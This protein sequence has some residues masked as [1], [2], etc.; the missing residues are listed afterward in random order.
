MGWCSPAGAASTCATRALP[1]ILARSIRYRRL[2]WRATIPA[3]I[4]AISRSRARS[5]A[6]MG[7]TEVNLAY[8]QDLMAG[9]RL[10]ISEGRLDAYIADD[11]AKLGGGRGGRT[12]RRR[13]NRHRDQGSS[14]VAGSG[15]HS[16]TICSARS[17]TRSREASRSMTSE[18]LRGGALLWRPAPFSST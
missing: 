9:A 13:P 12:L 6:M 5:S 17:R 4:G 11:A 1:T 15:L 7:L 18:R 8:Y 2:R 3:P 16:K 14:L 10:A